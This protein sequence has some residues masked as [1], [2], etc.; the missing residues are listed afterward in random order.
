MLSEIEQRIKE[1]I[2]RAGKPLK[3]WDIRIN[4]GIKTGFNEAFIIDGIK[5]QE[6]IAQDPKSAEIIRPILRGRDIKRYGYSFADLWLINSHNGIKE[7]DIKPINIADYPAIKNHLDSYYLELVKRADKGDTPYNLRNCAYMDDFSKQKII[8]P[9]IT[10]FLNFYL[11]DKGFF[12]NN[13]CFILTG[14]HIY[15][16]SA[17]FNSS[18]FKFCFRDDFPELLGGTRE[19]RKIFI[20]Q[21]SVMKINDAVEAEFELLVRELVGNKIKGET[22]KKI[23]RDIDEAIFNLYNLSLEERQSIGFIEI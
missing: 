10:K 7:N 1:K 11:D 12:V 5:R 3:E 22:S 15:F 21:I 8:Y 16:L 17:F 18:L 14:K 23:E 19:L 20:E 6:L 9:E 2:E 13:K 4:Y